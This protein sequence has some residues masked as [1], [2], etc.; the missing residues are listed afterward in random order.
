MQKKQGELTGMATLPLHVTYVGNPEKRATELRRHGLNR[1][2]TVMLLP[3]IILDWWWREA[4]FGMY[5]G[6][7]IFLSLS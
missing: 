7:D 6:E 2:A 4:C 1:A 3:S 5:T